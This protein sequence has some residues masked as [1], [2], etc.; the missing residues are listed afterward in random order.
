M[1]NRNAKA[2]V[3]AM[4]PAVLH[5]SGPARFSVQLII[6]WAMVNAGVSKCVVRLTDSSD[7][8]LIGVGRCTN[9]YAPTVTR[10]SATGV[11][12]FAYGL[13]WPGSA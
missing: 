3:T 6:N 8:I 13:V 4:T 10:V 9:K 12:I 11:A 1:P 2:L 7:N 5:N